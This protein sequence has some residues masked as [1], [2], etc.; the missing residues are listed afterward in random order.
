MHA[1]TAVIVS[2]AAAA[3]AYRVTTPNGVQ[4]W[5]T[6]GAQPLAWDRVSTDPLNFTAVLVNEG[7]TPTYS[8]ILAALVD[9][10]L[11]QTALNPPSNGWPVGGGFQVNLVQDEQSL[12]TILAQ[13][14][15]FNITPPTSSTSGS[16]SP[17]AAT[18]TY[19]APQ[20]T[21]TDISSDPVPENSAQHAM[22]FPAGMLSLAAGLA[23]LLV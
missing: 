15:T 8:Q 16:Y 21:S 3:A 12:N 18:Y 19:A 1:F 6:S 11:G 22:G 2:F 7:I 10:N 14:P 5:T 9:G 23:A 20:P 17:A 4:G 13:S